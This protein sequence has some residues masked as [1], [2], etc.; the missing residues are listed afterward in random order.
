MTVLLVGEQPPERWANDE[1]YRRHHSP[2]FPYPANSAG[3]RLRDISDLWLGEYIHGLTRINLYP[4]WEPWS[5]EVARTYA[6]VAM[7][8][9]APVSHV[10]LC[11]KRVVAA[12]QDFFPSGY[13][14]WPVDEIGRAPNTIFFCIPHPSGRN[15]AYNDPDVRLRVQSMFKEVRPL[16]ADWETRKKH[17]E[18]R[19][20]RDG[21]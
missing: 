16:L 17:N 8:R 1:T 7:Q 14:P 11:G 20:A 21:H 9:F 6:H 19:I 18:N 13:K 15:T 12:F 5:K 3:G 10:F 4:Q 2:M